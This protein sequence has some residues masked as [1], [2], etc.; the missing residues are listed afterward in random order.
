[1]ERRG[2]RGRRGRGRREGGGEKG[3]REGEERAG[4]VGEESNLR[5]DTVHLLLSFRYKRFFFS[6]VVHDDLIIL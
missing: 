2:R 1:M 3:K 6:D 4:E 5:D